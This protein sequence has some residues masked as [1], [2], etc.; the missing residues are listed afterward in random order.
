MA[1]TAY[2]YFF[3]YRFLTYSFLWAYNGW[4]LMAPAS[5]SYDWQGGSIPLVE[6]FGD[7]R[8]LATLIAV[9]IVSCLIFTA[10]K[11]FR[12]VMN[13]HIR[14]NNGTFIDPFSAL[15]Y[16]VSKKLPIYC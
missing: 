12:K 2:M 3:I 13:I 11:S 6:N 7:L 14:K 15:A 5:L 8:N 16:P 10:Y 4:L 9:L 1:N